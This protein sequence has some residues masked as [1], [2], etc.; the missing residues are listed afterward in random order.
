M[1]W[2]VCVSLRES[3]DLL[4]RFGGVQSRVEVA[5]ALVGVEFDAASLAIANQ[6]HVAL[7]R[8]RARLDR[9]LMLDQVNLAVSRHIET[10]FDRAAITERDARAAI[11]AD[12][13]VLT[14]GDDLLAA[15]R[16]RAHDR[17]AAA[18]VGVL[19]DEDTGRDAAFDHGRTFSAGV[20]VDE[21]FVHDRRA[22]TDIGAEAHARAVANTDII[23]NN[24]LAHRRE[25][26]DGVDPKTCAEV[27]LVVSNSRQH[28]A[29]VRPS[30]DRQDAEDAIKLDAM[31]LHLATAQEIHTQIRILNA[32]RPLAV[33]TDEGH[34]R[35][36]PRI[37]E[38]VDSAFVLH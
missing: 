30:N 13:T 15:A 37:R 25:L 36:P 14:D 31:R 6:E 16:E 17:S 7:A 32:L 9:A 29:T 4:G 28:R 26:V 27:L 2:G 34:H 20:E 33:V 3:E 21:A 22:F 1:S 12:Q 10:G 8:E 5:H 19:A 24:V 18:D 35:L 11:G 23:Q 38:N